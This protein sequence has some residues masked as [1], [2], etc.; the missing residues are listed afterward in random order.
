MSNVAG[1][2]SLDEIREFWTEQAVTHGPAPEASWS[3]LWAID[4]EIRE[5]S[6][7]LPSSG[8]VLDVGCANGFSTFHW[9]ERGDVQVRG[10]D[11]IPDMIEHANRRREQLD[12]ALRRRI[13]FGVGDITRLDEPSDAYDAVVVVRVLINLRTWEHQ[14]RALR[15]CIRVTR[16]GGVLL[17]S[18]ATVQGLQRL[19]ALRGEWGLPDIPMPGFNEYLDEDLVREAASAEMDVEVVNFASTYFV[20][21]RVLK[22]LLAQAATAEVDVANP[23]MEFNRFFSQ[24]PGMGDYGTQK[25]FVMRKRA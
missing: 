18:E 8:R 7:R 6:S 19:N 24:L 12:E 11:Y 15:E 10:L 23:R 16:P 17:L 4:L 3:D 22:P 25:L 21:T 1:K 13:S 9:A 14:E 5:I 2:L 20:G